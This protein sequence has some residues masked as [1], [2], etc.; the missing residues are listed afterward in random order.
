MNPVRGSNTA[1]S[2]LSDRESLGERV[3]SASEAQDTLSVARASHDGAKLHLGEQEVGIRELRSRI[4]AESAEGN[5]LV[6]REEQV[7][8]R[9]Y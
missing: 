3:Q 6:V 8:H 5:E 2:L 4:D 1:E 7:E 9:W